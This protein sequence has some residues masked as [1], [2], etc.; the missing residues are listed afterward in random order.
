MC[1]KPLESN[2]KIFSS[3]TPN[4]WYN[5]QHARADGPAPETTSF[6]LSMDF[7]ASSKA[8]SKAAE[9]IIAVPC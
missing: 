6:T 4:V 3:L 9:D 1:N 8:F 2:I 7:F 5:M